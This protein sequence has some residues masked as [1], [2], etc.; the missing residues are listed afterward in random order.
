MRRDGGRAGSAIAAGTLALALT[1]CT[2][3]QYRT[4]KPEAVE[5]QESLRLGGS[6]RDVEVQVHTVI[7]NRGPGS[8]KAEAWWDEYVVTIANRSNLPIIV[9]SAEVEDFAGNRSSSET[10]P[11]ALE[12]K[13]QKWWQTASARGAGYTLALGAGATAISAVAYTAAWAGSTTLAGAAAATTAA[14]VA[15]PVVGVGTILHNQN[16]KAKIQAEFDRRRFDF[17][18][19]VGASEARAGSFFFRVS[20]GPKQLVVRFAAIDGTDSEV[21]VELRPLAGLHFARR[22]YKLEK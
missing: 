5:P 8:W 22:S 12:R 15:V 18:R 20:P 19:P 7:V 9:R 16:Q 6:N 21:V 4:V 3:P 14:V 1:S 10:E 2:L 17:S 11:W 13:S